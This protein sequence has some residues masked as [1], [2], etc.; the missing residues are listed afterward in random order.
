MTG[1]VQDVSTRLRCLAGCLLLLTACVRQSEPA[2]AFEIAPSEFSGSNALREVQAFV[3]LGPRDSGTDGAEK[4][5]VYLAARFEEMGADSEIDAFE[6]P[7]P[8]G[9]GFLPRAREPH[10]Q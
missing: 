7:S 5:A 6:D 10:P 9:P 2:A 4:A 3:D 1:V 8:R